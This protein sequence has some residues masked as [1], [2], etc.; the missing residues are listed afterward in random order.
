VGTLR[1]QKFLAEAGVASRRAAEKMILDGQVRVNGE[2]ARVLGCKV[3]PARDQVTVDGRRVRVRRKLYVAANKPPGVVCTRHDPEGRPTLAEL[4]PSEWG[5]LFSVGR[6]DY[7]SEGLIF[8]TNDGDF[9]LKL[10]HPR[11]GVRKTY[12]ATV[13]GPLDKRTVGQLTRGVV[14]GRE[15]LQ[16]EEA[17]VIS[18]NN[19]R[20]VIEL[21]LGEGKNREVRRLLAALG[22]EVE[23]LVRIRIGRIPLGDL[24]TGKWRTLTEP[25]I[26]SLLGNYEKDT[27]A[28]N[29]DRRRHLASPGRRRH[30]GGRP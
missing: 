23:R 22:F 15:R 21:A 17:R 27:A 9:C 1:L 19:T 3:D 13:T 10:T 2:P 8:L 25:E 6:L 11:Y 24:R 12:Q 18:S 30:A 14:E 29:V 26:N 5:H 28:F 4:L 20:S 7:E 16:A